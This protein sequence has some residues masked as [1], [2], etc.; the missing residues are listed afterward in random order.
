MIAASHAREDPRTSEFRDAYLEPLGIT[1]MLDAPIR[2]RGRVRGVLCLEHVG[3]ARTWDVLEQCHAASAANLLSQAFET[4]DRRR[5]E[6]RLSE[7]EHAGSIGLLAA[8]LAHDFNN[9]LNVIGG[10]VE[11]ALTRSGGDASALRDV[12]NELEKARA[13]TR[14]LMSLR[15]EPVAAGG[16]LDLT[17]ELGALQ[18]RLERQ[19][20]PHITLE[21]QL[22]AHPLDVTLAREDLEQ[23]LLNL[24]ANA[25]DAM[26]NGGRLAVSLAPT[27]GGTLAR[28]L[29]EDNGVGM[30][31]ETRAHL[32]EPFFSTKGGK[33]GSGLGL[34]SVFAVVRASHGQIAVESRP[35]E[36]TRVRIDWPL[37]PKRA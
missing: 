34:A 7:A 11:L 27:S 36:G 2:S 37:E 20:G 6:R 22:P 17:A 23:V 30:D 10:E 18:K 19:V 32:F 13:V 21:L 29:V 3:P 28:L 15:R 31:E 26:P 33:K 8:R 9:R 35:G 16:V 4:R 14:N 12:L 24:A 1:S 25:R 5:L